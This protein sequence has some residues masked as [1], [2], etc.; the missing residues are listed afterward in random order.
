MSLIMDG[1]HIRPWAYFLKREED[2][3]ICMHWISINFFWKD[4]K[5]IKISTFLTYIFLV[6]GIGIEL[7]GSWVQC[8]THVVDTTFCIKILF[9]ALKRPEK[10]KFISSEFHCRESEKWCLPFVNNNCKT[11]RNFITI[12]S[13]FFFNS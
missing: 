7:K 8:S 4:I 13:I 11:S 6:S 5:I 2:V 9:A 1:R 3:S 12:K 10:C